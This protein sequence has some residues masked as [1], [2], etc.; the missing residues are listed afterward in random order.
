M[1]KRELEKMVSQARLNIPGCKNPPNLRKATKEELSNVLVLAGVSL[2]A[3]KPRGRKIGELR[4][5]LQAKPEPIRTLSVRPRVQPQQL[6]PRRP[7]SKPS[8]PKERKKK[9]VA[10][11]GARIKKPAREPKKPEELKEEEEKFLTDFLA[12]NVIARLEEIEKKKKEKKRVRTEEQKE[13]ARKKRKELKAKKKESRKNIWTEVT[14]KAE[15]KKERKKR[16]ISVAQREAL[17]NGREALRK[18]RLEKKK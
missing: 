8:R 10:Q 11:P 15:K 7:A 3:A 5:R 9:R 2:P 17:R 4:V 14:S 12:P 6:L 13:K 1:S 18:K 16:V